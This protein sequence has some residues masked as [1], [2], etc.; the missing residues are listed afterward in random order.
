[1]DEDLLTPLVGTGRVRAQVVADLEGLEQ[2]NGEADDE[3]F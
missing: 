1:M 2:E 3:P